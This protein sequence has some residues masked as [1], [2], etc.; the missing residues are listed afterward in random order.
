MKKIR[1]YVI[2]TK[3][4]TSL[5]ALNKKFKTEKECS[6]YIEQIE[7]EHPEYPDVICHA[8]IQGDKE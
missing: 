2:I 7:R 1:Y 5:T 4:K 6:D 3:S 8:T